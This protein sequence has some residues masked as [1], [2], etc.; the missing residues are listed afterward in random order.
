VYWEAVVKHTAVL[1]TTDG[2]SA[3]VLRDIAR[4]V[5][6]RLIGSPPRTAAEPADETSP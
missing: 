2:V 1:I 3:R 5:P 6:L 4:G